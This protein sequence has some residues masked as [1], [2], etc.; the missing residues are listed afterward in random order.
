[1][2]EKK[3]IDKEKK[4]K[5]GDENYGLNDELMKVWQEEMKKKKE[6][7]KGEVEMKILDG[8]YDEMVK[9]EKLKKMIKKK[10]D[11]IILVNIEIEEGEKEV[12]EEREE[13]IKVVGQNKRV[14]YDMI[15]EYVG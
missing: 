10:L 5:I 8:R 6:V 14:K 9:K 11:E 4:M 2:I 3:Q 1:M 12:K 15:E 13:G 7:K